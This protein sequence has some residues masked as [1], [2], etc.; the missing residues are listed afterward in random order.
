MVTA[1]NIITESK[2]LLNVPFCHFGRSVLG[3]DCSGLIWLSHTRAGLY[4]P[5]T[6]DSYNAFWWRDIS[7]KE[8]LYNGFLNAA[9]FELSDE[10]VIGGLVLF[11]IYGKHVPI[12]HCGIIINEDE[13]IH[14]KCG[15]K[16]RINRISLDSLKPGYYKRIAC[17]M[18]HKE[19]DYSV[20]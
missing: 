8:R 7:Q 1:K 6:D 19:V 3:L 9:N 11:R 18:K 14:A 20:V 16:R 12:N 2:K 15:I 5:R 17:F 13:F 4:M 10:L